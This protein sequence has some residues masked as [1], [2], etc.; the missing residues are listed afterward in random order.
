MFSSVTGDNFLQMNIYIYI[1][2]NVI[3]LQP[4]LSNTQMGPKARS[5]LSSTISHM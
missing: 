5:L 2:G 4:N 1:H 3:L